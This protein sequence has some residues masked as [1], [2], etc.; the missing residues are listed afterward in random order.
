MIIIPSQT[1]NF[2]PPKYSDPGRILF[3]YNPP[4]CGNDACAGVIDLDGSAFWIGEGGFGD[5]W[6]EDK[7][8][9][10]LAGY[11]VLEGITGSA[12]R[13]YEGDYD[14]DW[15]FKLCRRASQS[16]IDT[17]ALDG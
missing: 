13:T 16:E 4:A 14:E 1:E 6:V 15:K 2:E 9:L 7:V 11:Y 17:E 12:W 8:D 10:E 3:A 5:E